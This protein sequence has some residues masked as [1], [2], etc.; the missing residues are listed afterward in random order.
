MHIFTHTRVGWERTPL[1]TVGVAQFISDLFEPGLC[2][3]LTHS[4]VYKSP[5]I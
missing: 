2:F 5:V 1:K 4:R 3:E